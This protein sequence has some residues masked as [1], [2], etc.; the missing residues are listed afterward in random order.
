MKLLLPQNN[1]FMENN[2]KLYVT[3][4]IKLSE[5]I[6]LSPGSCLYILPG[7][8]VSMPKSQNNGQ[9]NCMITIGTGATLTIDKTIQLDSNY[10]LYNIGTINTE[11][12]I[13]ANSS[14]FSMLVLSIL[15]IN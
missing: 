12:L 9:Q 2:L 14:V 4:D 10:K 3:E 11:N 1:Q 8:K 15:K 13:C 5:Q 7:K 6:Y